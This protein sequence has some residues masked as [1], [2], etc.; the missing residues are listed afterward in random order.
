MHQAYAKSRIKKKK[1]KTMFT[2]NFKRKNNR[3]LIEPKNEKQIK[4]S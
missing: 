2:I 4:K 3:V 1:K